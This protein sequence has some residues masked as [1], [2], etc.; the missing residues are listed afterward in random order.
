MNFYWISAI[1][2]V[3]ILDKNVNVEGIKCLEGVTTRH[4]A[5]HGHGDRK[6][7]LVVDCPNSFGCRKS[8]FSEFSKISSYHDLLVCC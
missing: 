7:K 2:V 1:L 5:I 8:V 4:D 3:F 6:N